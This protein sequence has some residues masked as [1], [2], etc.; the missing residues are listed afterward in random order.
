MIKFTVIIPAYNS[1]ATIPAAIESLSLNCHRD[2]IQELIVVDS[3]DTPASIEFLDAAAERGDI[4]L[5][6]CATKTM[7][8]LARNIGAH[9]ATSH[10]LVFI[11][12]DV[13]VTE[14][15]SRSIA[16]F[17][18]SGGQAGAGSVAIPFH[19]RKSLLP[20][21]QLYLQFNEYLDT[22]PRKVKP[23]APACNLFCTRDV[24]EATGGFPTIR[25]SE[26]VLFCL[27]VSELTDLVF[28]P[29]ARVCHVFR[30]QFAPFVS[31]QVLL[32]KYVNIYRR[33]INP[34]SF[35]LNGV[36]ALLCAP[37]ITTVKL[38]R[39]V[40]RIAGSNNSHRKAFLLSFP[41]FLYGLLCWTCGFIKGG[42]SDETV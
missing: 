33:S 40:F 34:T 8:S 18:A 7:P 20:L 29:E 2:F 21:G 32:G 28:L 4:R 5:I 38:L 13:T 42:F 41:V 12:S 36:G 1:L 14:Q 31:N 22:A 35:Y 39:I 17:F 16:V 11:D 37:A 10:Y 26:D 27:K 30:E 24:F 23:F 9:A 3:S 15:W 6:R 25:A 19:Q